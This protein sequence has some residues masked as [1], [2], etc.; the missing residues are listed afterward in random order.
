MADHTNNTTN[1]TVTQTGRRGLRARIGV[2]LLSL[3]LATGAGVIDPNAQPAAAA[4]VDISTTDVVEPAPQIV[5]VRLP[6][7]GHIVRLSGVSWS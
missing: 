6:S 1:N 4:T 5:V 7:I 2:G 3:G